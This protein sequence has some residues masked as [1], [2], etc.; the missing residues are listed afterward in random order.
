MSITLYLSAGPA[1]CASIAQFLTSSSPAFFIDESQSTT[2][3][4]AKAQ[5]IHKEAL[6]ISAGQRPHGV[7]IAGT[8]Q[9][10]FANASIVSFPESFNYWP[11]IIREIW[12][13]ECDPA[14]RATITPLRGKGCKIEL[15]G[16]RAWGGM[17]WR[18]VTPPPIVEP[19]PPAPKPILREAD[20][21]GHTYIG[22]TG[23][24]SKADI[25]AAALAA[26]YIP[27]KFVEP[28]ASLQHED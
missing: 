3:I 2:F 26:P 22:R 12:R 1:F 5:V 16:Y 8:V 21:Q 9:P 18:D 24:P 25:Y 13:V 27:P 17:N 7:V 14:F 6:L 11:K 19:P 23:E 10:S 20:Y 15:Q 4:T 28:G